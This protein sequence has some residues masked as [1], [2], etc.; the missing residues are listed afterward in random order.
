MSKKYN[1]E[2]RSLQ[3]GEYPMTVKKIPGY[4]IAGEETRISKWLKTRAAD[5]MKNVKIIPLKKK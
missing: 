5:C 3:N 1:R 2:T 4:S